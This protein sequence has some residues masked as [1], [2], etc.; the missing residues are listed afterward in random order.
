[1]RT[2]NRVQPTDQ[3]V[4]R[5]P[6]YQLGRE[7]GS[8]AAA[9]VFEAQ[10]LVL[11]RR[12][13][14]KVFR[15]MGETPH[16]IRR[17]EQEVRHLVDARHPGIVELLDRYVDAQGRDVLVFEAMDDTLASAAP[18]SRRGPLPALIAAGRQTA[19]ALAHLHRLGVVHRDLKPANILTT[20]IGAS[21]VVKL[22]DFGLAAYSDERE[23]PMAGSIE[24]MA[25]EQIDGAPASS[26]SDVYA[27]GLTLLQSYTGEPAYTGTT[28]EIAVQRTVKP[29]AIPAELPAPLRSALRSATSIDPADRIGAEEL[30]APFRLGAR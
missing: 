8:G 13:A 3:A 27:L 20:G 17:R 11:G 15:G 9:V 30:A 26:A 25:P 10:D 28:L 22:A 7:L 21:R 1:M 23:L 6:R 4:D 18:V 16:E 24:F 19:S 2:A 14:A 12:V 5:L 29:V